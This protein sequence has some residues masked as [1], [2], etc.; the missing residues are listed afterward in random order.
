MFGVLEDL[1]YGLRALAKSRGFTLVAVLSLGLGIG[2][3]TT[4][5]TLLNAIF[6]RPLPV[7]DPGRLAAVFTIDPSNPG[8]LLCSYP[9]YVDYRDHNSVFSSMLLYT[10]I[11]IS[12]TGP[13]EPQML[14]AQMVSANYF[15][16]LGV[17]PL[18]GRGFLPE[19]DASPGAI[20][21]AVI[22]YGMW[23][24]QFGRDP[25]ITSRNVRLNGRP[26]RI[27][28]VAPQ[29]FQ[30][31]FQMTAADLYLPTMMYPL[32]YVFPNLV[33]QRRALLFNAVGRLKPGVSLPQA[34]AGMQAIAQ[35]LERQYPKDNSGRRVKL[36]SVAE[37]ALNPKTRPVVFNAGTL[38]A[39]IS[40]L[41]LLIACGNIANLLL[42]RAAGRRREITVRL[43]LGATRWRLIR[44]LLTE[45]ILLAAIGGVLGLA[46][47]RWAG[48][49]LWSL[50]PPMF[51]HAGFRLDLDA[52]VLGFNLAVSLLTAVVFGLAPA[53]RGTQS[54]LATDLKERAGQPGSYG[55][56]WHPRS[57]LVVAQVALSLVALLGAGLFV[58]SLQNAGDIDPGFDAAH[59]G[60]VAFNLTDVGY[61]E[62]RGREYYQQVLQQAAAIPGIGAATLSKDPPFTVASA[63]TVLLEG[64][65]STSSGR[66]RATLTSVVWPGYFQTMGIPL[67]RGRDFSP[68]DTRTTPRA[69]IVNEAAAAAYW[70]GDN[71]I[72]KRVQFFGE[73]LPVEVIGLAR[74]ANYQTVGEPP[75]ALV[76][77]SLMQYYFPT[78]VLIVRTEG[79]PDSVLP[80]LR[81]EVQSL[82][83]NLFLQSESLRTTIRESLWAQRLSAGLLAVF[84]SLA[85]L[86][87]TI[88]IYGVISYSVSLRKREIG[89]RMALGATPGD[90]QTMVLSE[91]V[92]LVAIG[93]LAGTLIALGASRM[94][95]GMLFAIGP[96]DALT[97]VVV[98]AI[99][100]LV[101]MTA[102]W[103]P[104]HRATAIDPAIAL[105]DE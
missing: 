38:L 35:E 49:V 58:R 54:N 84:G 9:N 28:G 89:V 88:G 1:R 45:S 51:N 65:E 103:V 27:V 14:R 85:L 62:G 75:Q 100:A 39:T 102:C 32:I 59:L 18:I 91:G 22:S 53:I 47:A 71:A 57:V 83:H 10:P 7:E 6:L 37:A 13:A 12:L 11:T 26:F 8:M 44:Q 82:D 92:R 19:E 5:F 46:L 2:A 43:A 104:A 76:Y 66:G 90:V 93:V 3:N 98:P 60:I 61:N 41:V 81:R 79:D 25:R 80:S 24:W 55:G 64:Q 31:L 69:A 48:D 96:R 67:L 72:G 87:S 101:A 50:R 105:R 63:R 36:T 78:G 4:I 73:S 74:N 15:S 42:A 17:K 52:R 16:T 68:L 33:N 56:A 30:G 86:L 95:A 29:G 23:T 70:P 99:L 94:V 21:V 97:F 20:A 40:A 34:E 77:L